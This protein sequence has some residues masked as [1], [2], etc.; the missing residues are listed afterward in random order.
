V[1][2][3]KA[4]GLN[5][6][7]KPITRHALEQSLTE[8]VRACHPELETFAG[9]IVE[10][11]VPEKPG[12]PNWAVKGVKFGTADRHQSGI[13]LSYCAHDAQLEYDLSD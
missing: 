2:R 4:E 3:K 6:K 8:A 7:R 13:I 10:R 12:D 1:F 9:V 11:V 5:S